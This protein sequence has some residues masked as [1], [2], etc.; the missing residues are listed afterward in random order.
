MQAFRSLEYLKA[1]R[2]FPNDLIVMGTSTIWK[3]SEDMNMELSGKTKL[4]EDLSIK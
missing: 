4:A 3:L 1:S 2:M